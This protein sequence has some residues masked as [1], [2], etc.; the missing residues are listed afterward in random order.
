MPPAAQRRRIGRGRRAPRPVECELAARGRVPDQPERVA[1]DPAAVALDHGQ[2][3]VRGDRRVNRRPAR[4][5]DR[6]ARRGREVV[7]RDDRARAA[8]GQRD[9]DERPVT[10]VSSG[11]SP[12][13]GRTAVRAVRL[14]RGRPADAAARDRPSHRRR[15][16]AL[17]VAVLLGTFT[18]RFSTGLTGGLLV[19]YLA[20]LP[21]TAGR[22][23]ESHVVGIYAALFFAAELV[24]S[25]AVRAD[26]GSL[27][28]P[29]GDAVR[30]AVRPGARSSS[31]GFTTNLFVLGGTRILEGAS[32]AASVPSI[33]GF[34][35]MVTAGDELLRGRAAARFEGAT[36]AGL[37]VG[38]VAAGLIW[39]VIGPVGVPPQRADLRPVA[40]D[41]PVRRHRP[42]ARR[43]RRRAGPAIPDC[44]ATPRS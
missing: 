18:L 20:D 1:T 4:S 43:A 41:L 35:A 7:R 36:L 34:I 42:R 22:L 8:A 5:E 31:P 16:A 32:T 19:Y 44:A 39:H 2:D 38:I 17:L 6:E 40:R 33:L 26:L 14:R 37:G 30:P 9:R 21:A 15:R 25:T 24:L 23:V 3:G 29:P 28:P 10:S 27:W 11:R 12:R 13:I